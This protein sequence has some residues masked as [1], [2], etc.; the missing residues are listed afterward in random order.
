MGIISYFKDKAVAERKIDEAVYSAALAEFQSGVVRPGVMAKALAE[1]EGDE[2]RAKG[3]YLKHLAEAIHDDLYLHKRSVDENRKKAAWQEAKIAFDEVMTAR[4]A[5][6]RQREKQKREIRKAEI[7]ARVRNEGILKTNRERRSE[8]LRTFRN[9][10][11]ITAAIFIALPLWIGSCNDSSRS[12]STPSKS[13]SSPLSPTV[14]SA[15]IIRE[16]T[17]PLASGVSQPVTRQLEARYPVLD[18]RSP[19]YDKR[20]VEAVNQRTN[21]Y[22]EHGYS[23]IDAIALAVDDIIRQR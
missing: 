15:P 6:K 14:S 5:E 1:C 7:A 16:S 18:P 17:K 19:Q 23:D 9:G 20:I 3:K 21:E 4:E 10:A 22:R 8:E 12:I 13:V 11:L 2:V